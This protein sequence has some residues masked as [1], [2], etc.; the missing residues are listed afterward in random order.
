MVSFDDTDSLINIVRQ[1]FLTGDDSRFLEVLLGMPDPGYSVSDVLNEKHSLPIID[2]DAET[3]SRF[4]PECP[5]VEC[6]DPLE[7]LLSS[8]C[9]ST[10]A[11]AEHHTKSDSSQSSK[12]RTLTA[13]EID[14]YFPVKP[15]PTSPEAQSPFKPK[16]S[17][18][19]L[20]LEQA[21]A[22]GRLLRNNLFSDYA[23]Y[24]GRFIGP[25][26]HPTVGDSGPRQFTVWFWR[27]SG[28]PQTSIR[29]QPNPGTTVRQFVGLSFWQYFNELPQA[30]QEAIPLKDLERFDKNFV[31]RIS[32]YMFETPA[33]MDES[34]FPPFEPSDP[35]HKYEFDALAFVEQVVP[36]EVPLVF[37]TIHLP[38]GTSRYRFHVT[39]QLSAVVEHAVRRRHLRQLSGYQYHL[40][41]WPAQPADQ[42][43]Q[44][45][46]GQKLDLNLRLSDVMESNLPLRFIL[47]RENSRSAAAMVDS[48]DD[49]G[50]PGTGYSKAARV[51]S[52]QCDAALKLRQYSVTLLKGSYSREVQLHV[53][54]NGIKVE[55]AATSRRR[56]LFSKFKTIVYGVH[57]LADCEIETPARA[58]NT[59]SSSTSAAPRTT[60]T[61]HDP[62]PSEPPSTPNYVTKKVQLKIIYLSQPETAT[63]DTTSSTGTL[64]V[65]GTHR[66]SSLP[67]AI[68]TS[69][70]VPS[71]Q[72]LCFETQWSRARAI[73]DQLNL[74][75][76]CSGSRARQLYMKRRL[77]L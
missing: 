10:D 12:S 11:V 26:P 35:I 49:E 65:G 25:G 15:T 57:T 3:F 1:C 60:G 75:L 42:E 61:A 45:K 24:D 7:Y 14:R 18:L 39:T 27:V 31:D 55:Q 5:F 48:S 17:S 4:S 74:I 43:G 70:V 72:H 63:A 68:G 69:D 36:A 34:C 53:S 29:V 50:S 52:V 16:K 77:A 9:S 58:S 67:S 51:S 54:S 6:D 71:F 44:L 47:V 32:V 66:S 40:E 59:E 13:A 33:D 20:A 2:T 37:V 19:T 64:S 28:F 56:K 38:Q 76:E 46:Q 21:K 62:P 73:C 41:S 22:D 23:V 8:S 30:D